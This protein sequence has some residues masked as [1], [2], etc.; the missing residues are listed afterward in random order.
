MPHTAGS[1]PKI[2]L[3][4]STTRNREKNDPSPADFHTPFNILKLLDTSSSLRVPSIKLKDASVRKQKIQEFHSDS[5]LLRA[6]DKQTMAGMFF[7][8]GKKDS[9]LLHR[10]TKLMNKVYGVDE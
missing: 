9:G 8:D 10:L 6:V 3:L 7:E 2:P 5:T 1:T 4:G